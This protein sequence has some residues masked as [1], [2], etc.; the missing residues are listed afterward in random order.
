M[1][2]FFISL[3]LFQKF[4][5]NTTMNWFSIEYFSCQRIQWIG[6]NYFFEIH[7]FSINYFYDELLF[8][9][10]FFDEVFLEELTGYLFFLFRIKNVKYVFISKFQ[11]SCNNTNPNVTL[12][13]FI[14]PNREIKLLTF[15]C[16]KKIEFFFS[17]FFKMRDRVEIRIYVPIT[18]KWRKNIYIHADVLTARMEEMTFLY[19]ICTYVYSFFTE[20]RYKLIFEN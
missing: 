9:K 7:C 17:N 2:V 8:G 11:F 14:I 6:Y 19:G 20:F 10:M 16:K 3:F 5:N 13:N 18:Y 4:L 1:I 12:K 15:L